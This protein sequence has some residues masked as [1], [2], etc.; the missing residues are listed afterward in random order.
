MDDRY[1]P[2]NGMERVNELE[3]MPFPRCSM[4]R[5]I[6]YYF[7][8]SALCPSFADVLDQSSFFLKAIAS[9]ANFFL[10]NFNTRALPLDTYRYA[11][12]FDQRIHQIVY[13]R[14]FILVKWCSSPL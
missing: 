1:K 3:R 14:D 9:R 6:V 13:S 5:R 11:F 4:Q 2:F 10:M 7:I 8:R 12:D